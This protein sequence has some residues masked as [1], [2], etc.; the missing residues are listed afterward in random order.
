MAKPVDLI[1]NLRRGLVISAP[2]GCLTVENAND[3]SDL[4]AAHR[5]YEYQDLMEVYRVVDLLLGGIARVH[6]DKK[7]VT[8]DRFDDL[9]VINADGSRERTQFKHSDEKGPSA[10]PRSR[11]TTAAD[12]GW[13][14]SWRLL[15]PIGTDRARTP[16]PTGCA[17]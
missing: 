2:A 4:T 13:T 15:S 1:G 17:S 3:M 16:P 7:L 9:T 14:V 12:W 6:V 11:L 10:T 5:G 8:D